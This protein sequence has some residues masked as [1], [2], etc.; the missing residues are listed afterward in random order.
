ML[1]S[2]VSFLVLVRN[3]LEGKSTIQA[4][5]GD[6]KGSWELCWETSVDCITA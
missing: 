1:Y 2:G 4:T 3:K 6:S 5:S